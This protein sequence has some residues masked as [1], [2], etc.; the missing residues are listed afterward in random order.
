L[1]V[2]Q[3]SNQVIAIGAVAFFKGR[4]PPANPEMHIAFLSVSDNWQYDDYYDSIGFPKYKGTLRILVDGSPLSRLGED[5]STHR[6]ASTTNGKAI[7]TI[8]ATLTNSE[9]IEIAKAQRVDV[10][11]LQQRFQISAVSLEMIR[12]FL[13]SVAVSQ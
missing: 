8:S 13:R 9:F 2:Y 11:L 3:D 6:Q 7:E 1:K 10:Q 4:T 5:F 12:E